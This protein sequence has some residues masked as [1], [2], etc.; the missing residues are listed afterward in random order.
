M[1]TILTSVLGEKR[2]T[3]PR[4]CDG[5]SLTP[6]IEG[7][8]PSFWRSHVCWEYDLRWGALGKQE[9]VE[10]EEPTP[11]D[12]LC[13]S[14]FRDKT[15]KYVHFGASSS[16]MAPL[17]PAAASVEPISLPPL[18]FDLEAEGGAELVNLAGKSECAGV[19]LAYAQ[20]MLSWRMQN[21]ERTLTHLIVTAP[22]ATFPSQSWI[23]E[24]HVD[25]LCVATGRR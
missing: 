8:T 12:G 1:P 9:I 2:A 4:Q 19:T 18:L 10:G 3:I 14:V 7:D 11:L 21:M 13:L 24:G 5:R 16:L 23:D 22:Q 6:F 20:K 17:D 25:G 15:H